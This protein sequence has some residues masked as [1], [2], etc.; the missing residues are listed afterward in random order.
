[1]GL[2]IPRFGPLAETSL[3]V[4]RST[5]VDSVSADGLMTDAMTELMGI[6]SASGPGGKRRPPKQFRAPGHASSTAVSGFGVI[7]G[8]DGRSATLHMQGQTIR[9]GSSEPVLSDD[10]AA[11]LA[12]ALLTAGI[13][14]ESDW[15]GSLAATI[16]HGLSRYVNQ[17]KGAARWRLLPAPLALVYTDDAPAYSTGVRLPR[18]H[19]NFRTGGSRPVGFLALRFQS[20]P[21]PVHVRQIVEKVEQSHPGVGYGLLSLLQMTFQVSVQGYTPIWGRQMAGRWDHLDRRDPS[22]W[23]GAS[24]DGGYG[25]DDAVPLAASITPFSLSKLEAALAAPGEGLESVL[26]AARAVFD[27]CRASGK[28][29][30]QLNHC[31]FLSWQMSV[32]ERNQGTVGSHLIDH[33]DRAPVVYTVWDPANDVM[34][35]MVDDYTEMCRDTWQYTDLTWMHCWL[36]GFAGREPQGA[37][38]WLEAHKRQVKKAA[39]RSPEGLSFHDP[40][41]APRPMP[42]GSLANAVEA[43]GLVLDVLAALDRLLSL[44][45]TPET[46]GEI[47]QAEQALTESISL[48]EAV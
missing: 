47:F 33:L 4:P 5:P 42:D 21:R 25:F 30:L 31:P 26:C 23:E 8:D 7:A 6:P 3:L 39:K 37:Q 13:L 20:Q 17:E 14:R 32:G 16:R 44:L 2:S 9:R 12:D 35:R 29:F 43:L 19:D 40:D 24:T 15:A 27:A 41:Y 36:A 34:T 38:K 48:T 10:G 46:L 1:M 45:H 28:R 18:W 22:L 11:S